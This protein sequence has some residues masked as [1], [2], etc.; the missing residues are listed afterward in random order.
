M[1]SDF[2][3]EVGVYDIYMVG[4]RDDGTLVRPLP[5][6]FFV[7]TVLMVRFVCFAV[8]QTSVWRG[9]TPIDTTAI[10]ASLQW[11]RRHLRSFRLHGL[12]A[13]RLAR[14]NDDTSI[15]ARVGRRL[16]GIFAKEPTGVDARFAKGERV[17]YFHTF[18]VYVLLIMI[19]KN[20]FLIRPK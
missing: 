12:R 1:L 18:T 16:R 14:N 2:K 8:Y 15:I 5:W 13:I 7:P 3:C 11:S 4:P 20:Y 19:H 17:I 10:V 9:Q 6:I